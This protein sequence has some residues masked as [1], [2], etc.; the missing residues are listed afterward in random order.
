MLPLFLASNNSAAEK[1]P[2]KTDPAAEN[3]YQVEVIL[4]D[5]KTITGS[6]LATS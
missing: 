6:E 2:P 1:D 5:Q 4:F 3:W